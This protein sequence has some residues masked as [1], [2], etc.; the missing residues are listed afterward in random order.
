M[1]SLLSRI[2]RLWNLSSPTYANGGEL[3]LDRAESLWNKMREESPIPT[4]I[5]TQAQFIPR[6]I[7]DPVK[8]ITEEQP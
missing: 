4:F 6:I 5:K 3:D 8:T 7:K 1:L 2:R